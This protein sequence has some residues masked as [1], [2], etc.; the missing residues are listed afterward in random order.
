MKDVIEITLCPD[1]TP[2][3]FVD[4]FQL[5]CQSKLLCYWMC[6]VKSRN[7]IPNGKETGL[8]IQN[9]PVAIDKK[10]W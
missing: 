10:A 7:V 4:L 1:L 9:D 5:C 2:H 6:A 8:I 3:N